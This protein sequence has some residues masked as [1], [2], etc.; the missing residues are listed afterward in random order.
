MIQQL[1]ELIGAALGAWD[2]GNDHRVGKLLIALTGRRP[3]YRADIDAFRAQLSAT[4][5]SRAQASPLSVSA[6]IDK[7][8]AALYGK[9]VLYAEVGTHPMT[10]YAK[11]PVSERGQGDRHADDAEV[12]SLR[13]Q[14]VGL[15]KALDQVQATVTKMRGSPFSKHWA[16][17]L[18]LILAG[19]QQE[20]QPKP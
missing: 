10:D 6:E 7:L 19:V 4:V 2:A 20:T 11:I 8:E 15:T 3:G 16:A 17:T 18:D 13:S 1:D 14:L 5:A 9:I 12:L